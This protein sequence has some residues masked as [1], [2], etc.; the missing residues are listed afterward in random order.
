MASDIKLN[1]NECMYNSKLSKSYI[2]EIIKRHHKN[3][4]IGSKTACENILR[5]RKN[6]NYSIFLKTKY[7]LYEYVQIKQ[8]YKIFKNMIIKTSTYIY[9]THS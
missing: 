3:W 2:K 7:M 1:C 6:A 5:Y 9:H 8:K 4:L